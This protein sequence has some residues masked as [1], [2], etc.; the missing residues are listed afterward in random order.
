MLTS[1][2]PEAWLLV[3][4]A[5]GIGS[6]TFIKL[7]S[8]F[9]TPEAILA[10]SADQLR[11]A[12]LAQR[13]V[14]WLVR[15]DRNAIEASLEW[16][17]QPNH[18]LLTLT[19]QR[20]PSLLAEIQDPPPILFVHGDPLLLSQPQLAIVGS[21]NPTPSGIHNAREFSAY[22]AAAGLTIISGLAIGIDG[23]A[24]EGALEKG[25]T[26]A[27][28][29][30]GLDRVYPARH[31]ALA[32][33]IL[34]RGALVSEFPPGTQAKPENFPRRNRIISG[35]SVGTLVVEATLRS[36]SL[37]TARL[38]LE[39]G[40]EVFA[41]PGSI[42]NPQA[43]GCHRL[44]REGA[45]LV[46][47]AQDITEELASL[48]GSLATYEEN[49]SI[50]HPLPQVDLDPDYAKLLEAMGFDPISVDELIERTGLTPNAVSSMLLLLELDG[51]VS[52]VP[53]GYY[54]R[55][56]TSNSRDTGRE[57]A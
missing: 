41:I 45:K 19:D 13:S 23:A 38:A 54:C 12:G 35:L 28:T 37:I 27:V 55:S 39:Q 51:H 52:S 33:R 48:L 20:Y 26:V 21:R 36:G 57:E 43:R 44:I 46:E 15:P 31:K 1:T 30:T 25:S 6:R 24:H 3:S 11:N 5:P 22:L 56:G 53:G 17:D 14:E 42:H 8:H 29:G 4:Q 50:E 18:H 10:A 40:R 7:L 47:S 49:P 32:Y 16:L 9:E 2:S 34:E